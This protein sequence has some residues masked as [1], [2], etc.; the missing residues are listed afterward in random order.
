VVG[1]CSNSILP[2][3]GIV[4]VKNGT[5]IYQNVFGTSDMVSGTPMT[6]NT[7]FAI[8]SNTKAMTTFLLSQL[9]DQGLISFDDPIIK[10]IPTFQMYDSCATTLATLTDILTHHTG[11]SRN[12]FLI[13]VNNTVTKNNYFASLKN[14]PFVKTFRY[15]AIYNNWM[16]ATAKYVIEQ[17][18][19]NSF[20]HQIKNNLFTP[21][22]MSNSYSTL[23][24]VL[25]TEPLNY[26][27]PHGISVTSGSRQTVPIYPRNINTVLD[28]I[29]NAAG[30]VHLSVND[31]AKYLKAL[32]TKNIPS[33]CTSTFESSTYQD[34]RSISKDRIGDYSDPFGFYFS[35][36]SKGLINGNYLGNKFFSHN[37][38]TMGHSTFLITYPDS[39]ISI[40]FFSNQ[41]AYSHVSMFLMANYIFD[42]VRGNNNYYIGP[43]NYCD[44]VEVEPLVQNNYSNVSASVLLTIKYIGTWTNPVYGSITISLFGLNQLKM[45]IGIAYGFLRGQSGD[46][47]VWCSEN[48]MECEYK[49]VQFSTIIGLIA[50]KMSINFEPTVAPY[51]FTRS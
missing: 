25:A 14:M 29:I 11:L 9:Y 35:T 1:T 6:N 16:Y 50:T 13:Y 27:Y 51:I 46:N 23:T 21:L 40:G 33:V 31:A 5:V 37:G 44:Y 48:L 36:Y 34:L 28:P 18:T 8:G 3:Y 49:N 45:Q 7:I 15:Q 19:G 42:V 2:G 30:G 47:F 17:V 39:A 10:Y 12:D 38:G 41:H 4:V 43:D 20:G 24:D 22:G 32:S 26:A